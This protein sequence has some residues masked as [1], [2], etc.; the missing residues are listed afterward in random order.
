MALYL[1]CRQA[2]AEVDLELVR[3][4][5]APVLLALEIGDDDLEIEILD[6]ALIT[7]L[8][9][10]FFSRSWPTNVISF[11]QD[12]TEGHLGDIVVSVETI[13]R[14]TAALGYSLEEG[15]VYYLI[16]GILHL[17]GYE[18]VGVGEEVA[19]VMDQRQD[20]LFDLALGQADLNGAG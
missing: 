18:H 4:F 10:K 9:E 12:R 3:R 2:V 13:S 8:N 20:E 11:P 17:L 7:Q 1:S 6:D 5:L 15:L 14:E 16:H 19:R